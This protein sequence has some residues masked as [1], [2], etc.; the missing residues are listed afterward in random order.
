MYFSPNMS[1]ESRRLIPFN[2]VCWRFV[3]SEQQM[4]PTIFP[5]LIQFKAPESRRAH[6]LGSNA[7]KDRGRFLSTLSTKERERLRQATHW[8]DETFR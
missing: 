1:L 7:I 4:R 5:D 2:V 6:P 3:K 8:Y